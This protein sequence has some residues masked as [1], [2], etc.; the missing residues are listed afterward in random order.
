[1]REELA[2]ICPICSFDPVET[3]QHPGG[4]DAN[5]YDC[6]RCG[7][8]IISRDAEMIT[9]RD[10]PDPLVSAWIRERK[11]LGQELPELMTYTLETIEKNLPKYSPLQK[12]HLLLRLLERRS[13]YFGHD[14]Q[15]K[16]EVDYPLVWANNTAELMYLLKGLEERNFISSQSFLGGSSRSAILTAGWEYLESHSKSAFTDRAFVAMSFSENMEPLWENAIK[17]AIEEAGYKAHR[18]DKDPHLDRI[19][20]KI[21][22][23]ILDSRFVVADVTE[24]KKGVYFEAGFALGLKLPVIWSVRQ[25]DLENIH[26]DTRQ[27][28]HIVWND[29]DDLKEQLYNLICATIG[30]N[31]S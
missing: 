4:R 15:L 31:K 23:D 22:A 21:I 1:M 6:P 17:P 10:T 20:A 19:D 29:S 16:W 30:K 28:N 8:F 14:V 9:R 11:E 3:Q 13:E 24:Q 27:Y 2:N 12:Q 26:F 7:P 25:D 5:Y 18:V